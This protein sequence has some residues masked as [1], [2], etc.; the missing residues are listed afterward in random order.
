MRGAI[1][2]TGASTAEITGSETTAIGS[3]TAPESVG[4]GMIARIAGTE[5]IDAIGTESAGMTKREG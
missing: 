4:T 1:V 5:T 3:A 2:A